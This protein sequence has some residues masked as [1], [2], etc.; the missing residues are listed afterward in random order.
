LVIIF[1]EYAMVTDF[2]VLECARLRHDTLEERVF[3][4][5]SYD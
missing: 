4:I 2:K 1:E 3:V 5:A